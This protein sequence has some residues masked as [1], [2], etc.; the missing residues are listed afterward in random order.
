MGKAL[1][2][3][4]QYLL[5]NGGNRRRAVVAFARDLLQ[6]NP[7]TAYVISDAADYWSLTPRETEILRTD[8]IDDKGN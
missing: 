6:E 7:D 1:T 3:T 5:E 8:L 4:Q 2:L